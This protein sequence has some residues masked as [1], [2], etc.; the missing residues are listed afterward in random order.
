MISSVASVQKPRVNKML[1]YKTLFGGNN[2]AF[3]KKFLGIFGGEKILFHQL[4]N[5]KDG[6]L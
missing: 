3:E 2:W 5:K 6:K 1:K 4:K